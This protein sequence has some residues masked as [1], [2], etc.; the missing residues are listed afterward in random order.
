MKRMR[1]L[2]LALAAAFALSVAASTAGASPVFYTK[3]EY[4]ATANKPIKFTGTVGAAFLEGSVS[5]SK[6]ECVGGTASGEVTGPKLTQKNITTFT[7]CKSSGFPCNSTGAGEG[8]VLTKSL[9]GELGD[10]KAGVPGL[11]LFDEATGKGGPLAEFS[12]AGGAIGV[13]VKGSLIGQLSGAAGNTVEE[14]KFASSTKLAFAE[15]GGIQ[16]WT[17]FVGEET[18]EQ[19]EGKLGEGAYE[20]SGQS[21]IA[22]L[23]AP[24]VSNLGETK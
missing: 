19:L 22:T 18:S 6:I 13:K 3:V 24:G 23:K 14:G 20:K 17:K 16:K 9:E 7:G 8:E 5:K 1:I 12:C 10:V 15:S 4:G 2:G 11:R 21:A